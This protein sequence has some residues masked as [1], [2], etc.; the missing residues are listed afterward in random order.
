MI[1]ARGHHLVGPDHLGHP[2][3]S[4]IAPVGLHELRS[5]VGYR[6]SSSARTAQVDA[7]LAN[8]GI[9]VPTS[10]LFGVAGIDPSGTTALGRA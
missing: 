10:D 4:S 7:A 8:E 9:S 1:D 5:L 3:E 2:S 6:H